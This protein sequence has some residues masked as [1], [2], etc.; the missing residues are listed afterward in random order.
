MSGQQEWAGRMR[1]TDV[2]ILGGG[3][4]GSLAAAMLGRAGI[5]ALLADP[6]QSYPP[7][8][9]CEK[10]DAEQVALLGRTGLAQA[11][12]PQMTEDREVWVARMG[13][14]VERKPYRQYDFLYD[15][16]VATVRG[17][18]PPSVPQLVAKANA[19][20]TGPERQRVVLS[21]GEE[22]SARLVV[23]ANGL[24]HA[25]RQSLGMERDVVS[26]NHSVSI[27]FNLAPLGRAGFDFTSLTYFAERPSARMAYLALFPVGPV[28]R[29]N[30]FTYRAVDDPWLRTMRR[31]PVAA[32]A[33]AMPGL[34]KLTG[35]FEV[36]SPV[37]IRPVDLYRTTGY[38][39][40]G[41]VLAGDAFATSCPA[42]GTGTSK[43]LTDVALLCS[44]HIPAWLATPGMGREKIEAFY[45][46]PAKRAS[47]AQSAARAFFLKSLSLEEGLAWK[48]R[49]GARFLRHA[50]RQAAHSLQALILTGAGLG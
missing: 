21:N 2:V 32:L 31:E 27:A 18:I 36:T 37:V 38:R 41:I 17:L 11:I 44:R 33:A 26:A 5:P 15:H 23:L 47:D 34:E 3:F 8:F 10:F 40:D 1:Q 49:R 39:R 22:V 6:H 42:A 35:A 9:R 19:I 43:V 29:A 45:D 46:D 20:E 30:L 13:R 25:F 14:L 28:T 4:A 16:L 7:D 50:G 12:L 48:A 24:N